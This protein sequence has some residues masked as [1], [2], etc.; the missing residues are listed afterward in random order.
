[1]FFSKN[2]ELATLRQHGFLYEKTTDFL[3][4][5]FLRRNTPMVNKILPDNNTLSFK[6]SASKIFNFFSPA[7]KVTK[8]CRVYGKKLKTNVSK[9]REPAFFLRRNTQCS[10]YLCLILIPAAI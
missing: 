7:K 3:N 10:E 4:A 1:M 5:F 2:R 9:N 8:K 6:P